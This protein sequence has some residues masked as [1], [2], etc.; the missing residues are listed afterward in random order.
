MTSELSHW[1]GRDLAGGRYRV[2]A[3]LGEGGMGFVFRAHDRHLDC[4]VVLK[5]PRPELLGSP[6]ATTRF[7]REVRSLVALAHPH[8][9]RIL[10]VGDQEDVPFFVL[11]YLPGGNLRDR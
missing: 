1:V 2:T 4:E 6:T 11:P 9:V 3:K 10:D 7:A 5:A 8:V